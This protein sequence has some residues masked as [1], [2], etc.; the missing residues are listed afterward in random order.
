MSLITPFL[1]Q[2]ERSLKSTFWPPADPIQPD[3][4]KQSALLYF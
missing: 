1:K 2:F 3:G 4:T